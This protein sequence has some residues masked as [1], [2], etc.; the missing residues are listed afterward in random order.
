MRLCAGERL[1]ASACALVRR[2]AAI[3]GE[4]VGELR[5]LNHGGYAPA[6]GSHGSRRQQARA[7]KAALAQ[8]YREHNRCC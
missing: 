8:R 2:V 4:I 7:F 5:R 1:Y 3:T 6:A